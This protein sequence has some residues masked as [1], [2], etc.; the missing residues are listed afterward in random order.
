MFRLGIFRCKTILFWLCMYS[1]GAA[2]HK[3]NRWS[4]ITMR[5]VTQMRKHGLGNFFSISSLCFFIKFG[6]S[7][8]VDR[9]FNPSIGIQR[10]KDWKIFEAAIWY[11]PFWSNFICKCTT[12]LLGIEKTWHR[13]QIKKTTQTRALIICWWSFVLVGENKSVWFSNLLRVRRTGC[14][15]ARAR[16]N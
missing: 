1:R 3:N 10:G 12:C 7:T 13:W 2:L 8:H 4:R 5:M 11:F 6:R 16:P 14:R 9:S 15:W